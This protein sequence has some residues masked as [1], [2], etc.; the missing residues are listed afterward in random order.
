MRNVSDESCRENQNK[1]FIFNN[2][3]YENRFLFELMRKNILEPDRP[4]MTMW[5]MRV[6]CRMPKA[7]DTHS[8]YVTHFF[9]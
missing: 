7:T 4:Q 8:E 9:F 5:R 3:F 1:C 6:A 2:D